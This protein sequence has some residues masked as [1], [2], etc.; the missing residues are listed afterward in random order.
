MNIMKNPVLNAII[1][2]I[3]IVFVVQMMTVITGAHHQDTVII[4]MAILSLFTLSA[5]IMG[6]LFLGNPLLMYMDGKKKD[7][8]MFFFKT[9]GS[10][11]V[12]T[13]ILLLGLFFG[14]SL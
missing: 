8:V 13:A 11:A 9:V 10:F 5:A 14:V 12:I 1:A 3:Y 6:Y 7:A 4:P 2:A